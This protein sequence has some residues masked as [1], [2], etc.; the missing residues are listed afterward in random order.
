MFAAAIP[1]PVGALCTNADLAWLSPSPFRH[2]LPER[3]ATHTLQGMLVGVN[4]SAT[5]LHRNE[6]AA[7]R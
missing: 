5:M 2:V 6:Q 4:Q 3:H 1:Q 7:P